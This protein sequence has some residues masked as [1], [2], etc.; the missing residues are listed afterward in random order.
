MMPPKKNDKAKKGGN[1]GPK[2]IIADS[3]V[4]E[5]IIIVTFK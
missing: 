5:V 2:E 1:T 4:R 3:Y